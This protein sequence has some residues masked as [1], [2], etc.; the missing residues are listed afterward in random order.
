VPTVRALD[1]PAARF[2]A[3]TADHGRFSSSADVGN[4]STR[5]Y[6]GLGVSVVVALV[7]AQVLGTPRAA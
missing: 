7:E 5:T 3:H 6:R 1:D 2:P 4:D